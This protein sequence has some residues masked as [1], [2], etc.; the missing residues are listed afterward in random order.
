MCKPLLWL[1]LPFTLAAGC[2][3]GPDPLTVSGDYPPPAIE[4]FPSHFA[5]AEY[6]PG[7]TPPDYTREFVRDPVQP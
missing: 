1:A 3:S 5:P 4:R 7:V 2:A 6:H